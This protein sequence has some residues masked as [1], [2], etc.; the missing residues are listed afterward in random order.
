MSPEQASGERVLD[1]R[2]DMYSL[3]TVLYEMLAGEPP[4]T[5]PNAQTVR[6]K[7]LS[8]PPPSVRRAR[9]AISAGVDAAIDKAL[10]PAPADRYHSIADFARTLATAETA[11]RDATPGT[12]LASSRTARARAWAMLAAIVVVVGAGA[13]F[14]WGRMQGRA[15]VSDSALAV[16]PF[17]NDGDTSNAYFADGITD[18]IRGK[19]TALPAL[20]VI[21]RAS[22][23]QYRRS[24]KPPQQIAQ[25]LGA[26]YLLT[27]VVR[28]ETSPA[29]VRR[30][31]VSP[32]LVQLSRESA[33]RTIWQQTFDTTLADVFQVQSSV[34]SKVAAN[35]GVVLNASAEAQIA[36]KPTQNLAAYEAYLRST[37]VDGSDLRSLRRALADADAGDCARFEFRGGVGARGP[38]AHR[39]LLERQPGTCRCRSG[40]SRDA[41][42]SL[43]RYEQLRELR[44]ARALLENRQVG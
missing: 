10:A 42:C 11:A 38:L 4:F 21:A 9:P 34:A 12:E 5:G 15:L 8:G 1:A 19:L 26:T 30:V 40:E 29:H 6:A 23:N 22:S 41:A 44:V 39:D 20:R 31:R 36:Q 7:M 14:L 18:E 33:P 37:A 28:W 13:F 2:T 35:L 17:E 16:L 25:E 32:E 3:A 27:G 24:D 43:S